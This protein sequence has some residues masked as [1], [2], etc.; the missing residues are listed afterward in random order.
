MAGT[1]AGA[2]SEELWLMVRTHAAEVREGL[3]P[4]GGTPCWRRGKVTRLPPAE[5]GAAEATWMSC[6]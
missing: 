5:E 2:V 6:Q 3:S 1:D 4:T